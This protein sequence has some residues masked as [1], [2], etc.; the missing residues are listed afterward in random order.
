MFSY[1]LSGIALFI[2]IIACINFVN[3]AIARSVQRSKEI[4]VRKV[5]GS[6]RKQ[7]IIQF[8]SES[9]ILNGFAFLIGSI[10]TIISLPLFNDLSSK[11]L[12]FEYLFDAKLLAVFFA[13]FIITGLMAGF[14][15]A[16]ILSGLKP[17]NTLYGKFRYTSKNVLQNALIV[18]QFSLASFFIIFAIVQY[19]QTQLFTGKSLGYSDKNLIEIEIMDLTLS[20]K[21]VVV[22]ELEKNPSILS[23]TTKNSGNW[24]T[25]VKSA[26]G[27][28]VSPFMTIT[29]EN[30]LKTLGLHLKEGRFFNKD[31]PSDTAKSALVN[32]AFVNNVGL[33]KPVGQEITVMNRDKYQIVG[34]VKDYH[35]SSLYEKV[36]PQV[37]LAN[38]N[39]GFGT[40]VIKLDDKNLPN[41]LGSIQQVFKAHFPFQ[42]YKYDFV[43][44]LNAKYYEKEFKM[45]A[46]ILWSALII[47]FISCIGMFGLA[48]LT[49]QKRA[50][51]IGIRKVLGASIK[52]IIGMLSIQFMKLVVIAFM[53]AIP[54]SYYAL[55]SLLQNLPY[56]VAIKVD[57]YIFTLTGILVLAALT[58]SFHALKAALSKPVEALKTE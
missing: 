42:P 46:M 36:A 49:T 43:S 18:F 48:A 50:K 25:G 33:K 1:F 55:N 57:I 6:S 31:F 45:R 26:D 29:D 10:I 30:F 23:V 47:I 20:K 2:L 52:S 38:P 58:S 41:T 37:I 32:E 4:G 7:L 8:L 15:P 34:I 44:D 56:R 54:L 17:V 5:A 14:Y 40:F 13:L 53:I 12:A 28:E 16:F 21:E 39:F 51:E 3:L 22:N 35:H 19:R 24:Y 9:F 27:S 11:K